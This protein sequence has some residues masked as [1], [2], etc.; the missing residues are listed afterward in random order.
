MHEKIRCLICHCYY[1]LLS[2]FLSFF[3]NSFIIRKRFLY[4]F[5][6][7]LSKAIIK[8][9]VRYDNHLELFNGKSKGFC[10]GFLFYK[11]ISHLID[12]TFYCEERIVMSYFR[13][14]TLDAKSFK[15]NSFIKKFLSSLLLRWI[16]WCF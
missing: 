1:S 10:S 15:E 9:R 11:Y 2:I 5:R 6:F 12:F 3:V 13:W 16:N 7:R 8:L 4:M 14:F